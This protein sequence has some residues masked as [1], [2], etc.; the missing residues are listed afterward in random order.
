MKQDIA[1]PLHLTANIVDT[2]L[3]E[4]GDLFIINVFTHKLNTRFVALYLKLQLE[5]QRPTTCQILL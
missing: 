1:Q 4:C 3:L 5:K 2:E